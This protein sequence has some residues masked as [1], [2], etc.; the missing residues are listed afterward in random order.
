ME[1]SVAGAGLGAPRTRLGRHQSSIGRGD[2]AGSR[3][4]MGER[5]FRDYGFEFGFSQEWIFSRL[6]ISFGSVSSFKTTPEMPFPFPVFGDEFVGG[7]L[8]PK[9]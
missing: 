8:V 7:G 6:S 5:G 9:S 4:G 1:R 2:F 3:L